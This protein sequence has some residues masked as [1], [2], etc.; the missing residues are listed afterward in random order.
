MSPTLMVVGD[1]EVKIRFPG[2]SI[3]AEGE[4]FYFY[5][6]RYEQL[7]P[8]GSV[9]LSVKEVV[10]HDKN[11]NVYESTIRGLLPQTGYA[12]KVAP[13]IKVDNHGYL[14][15]QL[16]AAAASKRAYVTTLSMGKLHILSIWFK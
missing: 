4:E 8:R 10:H 3:P 16:Y 5:S 7:N 15:D 13:Y 11:N 2:A 6:I 14:R 12:I 9:G 1:R